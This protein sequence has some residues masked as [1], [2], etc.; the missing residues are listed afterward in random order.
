MTNDLAPDA[1]HV[2]NKRGF[3]LARGLGAAALAV[4]CVI[5][6]RGPGFVVAL[7][8]AGLV[9]FGAFAAYALRQGLRRGPRLTLDASGVDAADLGAGTIPWGQVE[10]VEAFGSHEA[11]FIAF[12]VGDPAR[13]LA[14]MPAWP[15]L[16]QRLLRAQG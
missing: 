3:W 11:P 13:H 14:R 1:W 9:L 2:R 16:L 12:H 7:G 6:L 15:R 4:A 5:G 8:V 10:H